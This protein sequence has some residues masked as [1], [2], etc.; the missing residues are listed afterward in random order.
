MHFD[1]FIIVGIVRNIQHSST[2]ITYKI[3][4]NTGQINA[5]LLIEEEAKKLKLPKVMLNSYL[6]VHGSIRVSKGGI[7]CVMILNMA[8]V[9]TPNEVTTHL[10]EVYNARYKCENYSKVNFLTFF[11]QLIFIF[12]F[13]I[14]IEN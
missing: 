6:R 10:L 2:R 7:K 1:S 13:I 8:P 12:F 4:D 3:E 5:Y 9:K 14:N 11:V